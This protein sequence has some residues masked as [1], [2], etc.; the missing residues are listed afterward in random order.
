VVVEVWEEVREKVWEEVR[1]VEG[2][3][4]CVEEMRDPGGAREHTGGNEGPGR[5]RAQGSKKAQEK[6]QEKVRDMGE[7]M[8]AVGGAAGSI[9][10]GGTGDGSS[11]SRG[12]STGNEKKEKVSTHW[13]RTGSVTMYQGVSAGST[14]T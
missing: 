1:C 12:S 4:E 3:R 6:A 13:G 14:T 9:G 10:G 11:G 2:V 8:G 7:A 5:H